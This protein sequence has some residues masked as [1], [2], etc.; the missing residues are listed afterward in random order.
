MDHSDEFAHS[1]SQVAHVRFVQSEGYE[2]A[3]NAVYRM[4]DLNM[5][6]NDEHYSQFVT[7]EE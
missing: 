1:I 5:R 6:D 3:N 7:N 4:L 2:S